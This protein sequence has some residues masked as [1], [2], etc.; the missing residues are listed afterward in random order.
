MY[1]FQ[2]VLPEINQVISWQKNDDYIQVNLY[3]YSLE[4]EANAYYVASYSP[5]LVPENY[6]AV[7]PSEL[8]YTSQE[9]HDW[10]FCDNRWRKATVNKILLK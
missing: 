7:D 9:V 8:R 5:E 1:P 4:P 10:H 3:T 2:L 6:E